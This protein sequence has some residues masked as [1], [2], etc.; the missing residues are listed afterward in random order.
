MW[1]NAHIY[2]YMWM[3]IYIIYVYTVYVNTNIYIYMDR[4]YANKLTYINICIYIYSS[5]Y[6]LYLGSGHQPRSRATSGRGLLFPLG[7]TSRTFVRE[8][9]L[10]ASRLVLMLWVCAAKGLIWVV[11]Q[12]EGSCFPL[13]PR[14]QEFLKYCP[15]PFRW[16]YVLYMLPLLYMYMANI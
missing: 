9:N 12:P 7:D 10:L 14:W 13:H 16:I 15:V 11:E 1:I 8:G 5:M 2:I 3:Q 6:R 4:I